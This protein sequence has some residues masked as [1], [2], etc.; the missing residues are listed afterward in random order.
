MPNR[1]I[2]GDP[3]ALED[4]GLR[5]IATAFLGLVRESKLSGWQSEWAQQDYSIIF[6]FLLLILLTLLL[7]FQKKLSASKK[8]H[9]YIRLGFLTIILT[10]LGWIAQAQ[11]SIVNIISYAQALVQGKGYTQFLFEPLICI[12]FVFILLISLIL[13]GRGVFCGWLCPFGALQEIVL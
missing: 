2:T 11:L 8:I 5:P 13:L 4:A 9:S 1:L 7:I 6:L 12:I 10:W 3:V